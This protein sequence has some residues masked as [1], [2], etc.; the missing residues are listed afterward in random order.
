MDILYNFEK[1]LEKY[2]LTT[3]TYEKVCKDISDKLEGNND[4][5]WT[6]IKQ[7]YNISC[8]P[9]TIRKSSSTIFGGQFRT[10]YLKNRIYTN[11][12]DFSKEKELDKKIQ[13]LRKERTKL[14]TA[15]IERNRV[16]RSE[17]RHEMYYEYIG[18]TITSLPLPDFQPLSY[19]FENDIEY[20]LTIADVHYGA[21]F[22]SENN[23][24]SPGIAKE[25]FEDLSGQVIDFIKKH[26]LRKIHIVSLGDLI[27]GI[28]RVSDLK[29]NDSSISK[30]TV[31]ISRLIAM[32]LRE[33][34]IHAI[35]EYYHVPFANHTQ[36]RPLGTK[37]S[38]LAD[39]DVEY[40]IGNYILDLCS[41]NERIGVHL[42]DEGKQYIEIPIMGNEI[43]AMHGHQLKNVENS[44]RDLSMLRRSFIDY[45][46]LGHY[47]NGKEIP[48]FEGCC[49]DTEILISPS[50]VGS[51]PYSDSL[52]KGS[53]ASC[54]IYGF[55][56]LYGHTETHKF[57]LN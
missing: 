15:N 31:E 17:A 51:D 32:F 34:S 49:N 25:R 3:E 38:E 56:S 55:D 9:D 57:I 45:L 6:E 41:D 11:P 21:K 48:C 27:Q 19:N 37:A 53:K 2:G 42:A 28:L 29:V 39:E 14:Q 4:L 8:S 7:K 23:E 40:I 16:D 10:E 54:K 12:D 52:M 43:I 44:I 26:N 46:V 35:V 5:D 24:Y 1:E 50:F 20:L 47:H 30:A 22:K 18:N 33:I 13:D 36:I